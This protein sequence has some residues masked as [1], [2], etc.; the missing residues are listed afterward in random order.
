MKV[1]RTGWVV[2]SK[3]DETKYKVRIR[4]VGE[5]IKRKGSLEHFF[6]AMPPGCVCVC[7]GVCVC[8]RV[9]MYICVCECGCVCMYVCVCVCVRACVCVCECVCVSV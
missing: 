3:K 8:V 1:I 5:Q 7:V 4:L 2:V 6:V 9:Y